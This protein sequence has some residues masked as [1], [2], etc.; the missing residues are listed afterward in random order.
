MIDLATPELTALSLTRLIN[1]EG[2]E[3][4]EVMSV[5]INSSLTDCV[6]LN[7]AIAGLQKLPPSIGMRGEVKRGLYL[8]QDILVV[9]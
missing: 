5:L 4:G 6:L 1:E 3:V 7:K 2:R 9:D 8:L